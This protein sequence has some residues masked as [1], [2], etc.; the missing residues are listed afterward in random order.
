ML[1]LPVRYMLM[2]DTGHCRNERKEAMEQL[3]GAGGI[4]DL[5]SCD[6]WV[7]GLRFLPILFGGR[8]VPQYHTTLLE[9]TIFVVLVRTSMLGHFGQSGWKLLQEQARQAKNANVQGVCSHLV[10][11]LSVTGLKRLLTPSARVGCVHVRDYLSPVV[12]LRR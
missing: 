2:L 3:D 9:K 5:G 1:H 7:H 10:P 11:C 6:L 12:L 4:V 8:L